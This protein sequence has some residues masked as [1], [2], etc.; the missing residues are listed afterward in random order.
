MTQ[1]AAQ[2]DGVIRVDRIARPLKLPRP[3]GKLNRIEAP[4]RCDRPAMQTIGSCKPLGEPTPP[5]EVRLD[6]A[7][8][9]VAANRRAWATRSARINPVERDNSPRKHTAPIHRIRLSP[10]QP[11]EIVPI[12]ELPV[13]PFYPLYCISELTSVTIL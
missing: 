12:A 1:P 4:T 7:T 10:T 9:P 2:T 8:R 13:S 6:A 3:T 5:R 11:D